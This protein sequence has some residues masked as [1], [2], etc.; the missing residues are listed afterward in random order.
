[1][2]FQIHQVQGYCT[3]P[4]HKKAH[5]TAIFCLSTPTTKLYKQALQHKV[6]ATFIRTGMHNILQEKQNPTGMTN[7][8]TA[9]L[10]GSD[11][12]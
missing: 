1:M 11:R 6:C 8:L 2:V 5:R 4:C 12:W 7:S 3:T 10:P 9:S